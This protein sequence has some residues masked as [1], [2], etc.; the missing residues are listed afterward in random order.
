MGSSQFKPLN[1][2][3]LKINKCCLTD[4]RTKTVLKIHESASSN[5]LGDRSLVIARGGRGGR[6]F[7]RTHCFQ[8]NRA[9]IKWGGGGGT[10]I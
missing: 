10:K 5:Q 6:I 8:E 2:H 1:S 4:L 7:E 3:S 9:G